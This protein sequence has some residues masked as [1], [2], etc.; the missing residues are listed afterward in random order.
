VRAKMNEQTSKIITNATIIGSVAIIV[1]ILIYAFGVI[2]KQKDLEMVDE[3][4]TYLNESFKNEILDIWLRNE[5]I[6]S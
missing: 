3:M 4:Y 6:L 1:G 5:K 2:N